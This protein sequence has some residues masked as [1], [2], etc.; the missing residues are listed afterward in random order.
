MKTELDEKENERILNNPFYKIQK[1]RAKRNK[2]NVD[3]ENCN[4]EKL[5]PKTT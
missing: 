1:L 2:T 3:D 4:N 5:D